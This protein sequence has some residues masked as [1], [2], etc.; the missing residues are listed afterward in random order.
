MLQVHVSKRFNAMLFKSSFLTLNFKPKQSFMIQTTDN[1]NWIDVT[2]AIEDH[3]VHWPGDLPVVVSKT[4]NMSNGH[5]ANVTGISMSAH[6]AT[7]IDAPLHFL[8][9][10]KDVTELPLDSLIGP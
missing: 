10:G 9:R 1:T 3:M 7:H 4:H 5:D 8:E 2:V 6:T